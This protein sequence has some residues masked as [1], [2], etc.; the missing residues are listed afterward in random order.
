M[1]RVNGVEDPFANESVDALLA[2]RGIEPRG[3]AVALDGEVV[4]RSAWKNTLIP[5]R[6][7]VEIVT[8]AAGG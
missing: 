5:D 4:P 7:V 6:S 8:A 2:R 3:V 1:I